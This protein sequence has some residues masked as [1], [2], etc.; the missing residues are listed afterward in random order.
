DLYS[1]YLVDHVNTTTSRPD[2]P[3]AAKLLRAFWQRDIRPDHIDG[4]I[5]V[6]PIALGRVLL[7][8]G[9][10]TV[11]DVELTSTNAL[12]ILLKDVYD[13]W[14]PYASKAQAQA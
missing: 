5:S 4:V 10:I 1:A 8:T 11:G 9:P 6:D 7:A 14:N 13:W 3:T 12:S 2:F